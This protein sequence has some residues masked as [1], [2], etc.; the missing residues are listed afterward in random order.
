MCGVA[1][2]LELWRITKTLLCE[3]IKSSFI[4]EKK[5]KK[6]QEN[7]TKKSTTNVPT[8]TKTHTQKNNRKEKT[9]WNRN[10][11]IM[12]LNSKDL[13]TKTATTTKIQS[14]SK[15]LF[16][17]DGTYSISATNRIFHHQ[18]TSTFHMDRIVESMNKHRCAK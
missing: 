4:S 2:D 8:H 13:T 5:K 18:C 9:N 11:S 6:M 12:K 16:N 10:E 17:T 1:R 3:N 14:N 15:Q 7:K